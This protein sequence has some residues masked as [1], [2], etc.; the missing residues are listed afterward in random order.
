VKKRNNMK[1]LSILLAVLL[2]LDTFVVSN[3]Y[4]QASGAGGSAGPGLRGS[5]SSD[6][7]SSG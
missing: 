3:T 6:T 1:K 4:V 7:G 2:F 5:G